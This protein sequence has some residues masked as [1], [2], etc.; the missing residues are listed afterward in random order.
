MISL[1]MIVED[2]AIKLFERDERLC[3]IFRN[4]GNI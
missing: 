1:G 4:V 2:A 3:G